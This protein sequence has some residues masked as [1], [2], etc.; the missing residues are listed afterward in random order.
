[1][2]HLELIKLGQALG[3]KSIA[4]DG[5]CRGFSMMWI[6]AICIK[7]LDA[8]NNR[9]NLLEEFAKSPEKLTNEVQ[10]VRNLSIKNIQ[11]N[12]RDQAILNIPP[13]FESMSLYHNPIVHQELFNTLLSQNRSVLK[14]SEYTQPQYAKGPLYRKHVADQYTKDEL[15]KCLMHLATQLEETSDVGIAFGSMSHSVSARYM[16]N[17][18]FELIDTEMPSIEATRPLNIDE[19]C[20]ILFELCF[21]HI[22]KDETLI[23]KMEVF[24]NNPEQLNNLSFTNTSILEHLKENVEGI[25]LLHMAV[26]KTDEQLFNR[27][28]LKKVNINHTDINKYTALH[29]AIYPNNLEMAREL[30]K[31][32]IDVDA[33]D[34]FD[35]TALMLACRDNNIEMIKLL[36]DYGA[37]VNT[38]SNDTLLHAAVVFGNP[39][40]LLLILNADPT[41]CNIKD[42]LGATPLSLAYYF[43]KPE[44]V[45]LLLPY[46]NLTMDDFRSYSPVLNM[47][48]QCD[49]EI[50]KDFL[51]K[52]HYRTTERN[53]TIH[54]H[55]ALLWFWI[56]RRS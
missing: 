32:G 14:I 26:I 31:N 20:K 3:Y 12:D 22:I 29:C 6:Q 45:P 54:R 49:P 52:L 11:L 9:M 5:V 4:D 38:H 41:A 37:D 2:N 1:M 34:C 21:D 33:R 24:A 42:R 19:L 30:L 23:M 10:R 53:T 16:G 50:K 7:G 46:T 55:I 18:Q 13:F 15:K 40:T 36:L 27:I 8:F 39:E 56:L 47:M 17:N 35:N 43:N 51:G 44:F 25:N 48:S 28:D